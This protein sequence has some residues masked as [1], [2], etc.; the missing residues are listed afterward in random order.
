MNTDLL[1]ANMRSWF[2]AQHF[3]TEAFFG[4]IVLAIAVVAVALML[5]KPPKV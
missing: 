2:Y 5:F 3:S 1:F 4:G